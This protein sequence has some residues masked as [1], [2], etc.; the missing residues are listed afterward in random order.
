MHSYLSR[1]PSQFET[2]ESNISIMS[3]IDE[4]EEQIDLNNTFKILVATDIHL[5]YKES[6]A[7]R[8]EL[9]SLTF[10]NA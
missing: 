7:E 10:F 3:E 2:S 6:D 4:V 8:S 5:G 1:R 9:H